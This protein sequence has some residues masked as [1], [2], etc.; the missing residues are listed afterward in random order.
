MVLQNLH[1]TDA[2]VPVNDIHLSYRAWQHDPSSRAYQTDLMLVHG[3]GSALQIWDRVVPHLIDHFA[4]KI[5]TMDQRGHGRSDKPDDG[6]S[7]A[8]IVS[9]DYALA[10]ALGLSQPIIVGHSWGATIAMAY[11]IAHPE[12]VRAIMLV[13]GVFGDLRGQFGTTWEEARAEFHMHDMTGMPKAEF[14]QRY[15]GEGQGRY[16]RPIWDQELERI[17]F[18]IVR[19]RDDNTIEPRLSHA[20]DVKL[21]RTL[22]ET[23]HIDL[24]RQVT[25]PVLMVAAEHEAALHDEETRRWIAFKRD[26]AAKM[27]KAI[28]DR[29]TARYVVMKDTVHDIPLQR[30]QELSQIILNFVQEVMTTGSA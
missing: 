13:D 3:L 10:Q 5:V 14:L 11:A 7:T 20:N 27:L 12:A 24:A 23:S 6:Y 30:P 18:D 4:G 17:I 25:R 22:W 29:T 26:G 9:D 28:G 16:F 1:F 8:Q 15:L 19:L 21:M 2:C